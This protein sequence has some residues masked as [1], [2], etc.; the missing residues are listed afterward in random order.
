[1]KIVDAKLLFLFEA[2]QT[3]RKAQRRAS[4]KHLKEATSPVLN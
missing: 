1:M 2:L 3:K 4:G